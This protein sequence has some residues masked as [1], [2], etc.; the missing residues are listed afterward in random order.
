MREKK[1]RWQCQKLLPS[2]RIRVF[3]VS[4][5]V[6]EQCHQTQAQTQPPQVSLTKQ[7]KEAEHV[8]LPT[9]VAP[10]ERE[11]ESKSWSWALSGVAI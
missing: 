11:R 1:S 3:E 9:I 4:L 10:L 7:A 6:E 5:K 2:E 8:A